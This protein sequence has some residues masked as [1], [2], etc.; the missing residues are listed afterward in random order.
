MK[1]GFVLALDVGEKRIGL[2]K[3]DSKTGMAFPFRTL[4]NDESFQSK[5]R[6]IINNEK[7]VILVVGLP[8]GMDGQETKQTAYARDFAKNLNDVGLPIHL[9]DEAGTSVQARQELEDKGQPF[10]KGDIDALAATYILQDFL[11]N[12]IKRTTE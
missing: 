1:E 6:E 3:A 8:R 9:Q 12:N 5:L 4:E 11:D 10:E 7:I 2:A